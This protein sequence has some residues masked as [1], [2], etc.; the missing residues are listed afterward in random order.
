M[1]GFYFI[2]LNSIPRKV[3]RKQ[4]R[5]K[6]KRRPQFMKKKWEAKLQEEF[7]KDA[8]R[9]LEE[10][11]SDPSLRDVEAPEEIHERLMQQIREY[12]GETVAEADDRLT[13]EEQELIQLGRVYKRTRRWNRYAVLAAAVIAVLAIGM[14]SIGGPQ[15]VVQIVREMV[16]ERERTKV[17][18]D[19]DKIDSAKAQSE[20]ETY[21]EIEEAFNCK[22]VR[23]H[24][25]P[26]DVNCAS[27][28]IDEKM[29][30]AQLYYEKD[31]DKVLL[32]N[33][34]FNYRSTSTGVD[35]EDELIQEYTME[36]GETE[37]LLKQYKVKEG[38]DIR[39]RAEFEHQ[40]IHYFIE[41]NG[42]SEQEIQKIV[43]NLH[44]Y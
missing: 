2:I 14:T 17:N 40:K 11:N 38:K 19:D 9:I 12:E 26:E 8:E 4:K 36:V 44:F 42:F 5:T 6:K 31:K 39:W 28:K 27:A 10:V 1:K 33:I 24:Y 34:W 37:V 16:N 15:K 43:K 30:N 7:V 25:L 3:K 18:V 13:A 29:Q 23:L 35:V 21:I 41:T 32:Y 22:P 20:E